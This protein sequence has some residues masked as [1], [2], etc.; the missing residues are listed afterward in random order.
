MLGRSRSLLPHVLVTASLL[1][2]VGCSGT[3]VGGADA[4]ATSTEALLS[5]ERSVE[6]GEALGTPGAYASAHFLRLQAGADRKIAARL[7]GAELSLPEV[8]QCEPVETLR[9]RGIPL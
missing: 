7:V 6:A 3:V 1:S 8:G 9:D 2:A 4:S 5:V